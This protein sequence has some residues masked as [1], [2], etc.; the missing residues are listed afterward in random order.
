M[1]NVKN[2]MISGWMP[3]DGGDN[4]DLLKFLGFV[5][6]PATGIKI[7]YPGGHKWLDGDNGGRLSMYYFVIEGRES[8]A[9]A[10]FERLA[11]IFEAAG[12]ET[13]PSLWAIDED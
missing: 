3:F 6:L 2:V 1:A 8:L 12:V 11:E 10:Y 4:E 5:N 13:D 9:Y 7:Q